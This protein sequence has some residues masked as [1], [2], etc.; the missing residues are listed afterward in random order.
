L[1]NSSAAACIV[2]QSDAE[3]MMMPT[4]GFTAVL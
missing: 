3:P 4:S 2:S 1:S